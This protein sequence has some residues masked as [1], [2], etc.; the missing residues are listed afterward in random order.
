MSQKATEMQRKFMRTGSR[1]KDIFK[2][3]NTGWLDDNV[4]AVREWAANIFFYRKDG[5]TIMID[6]GYSYPGL[7]EK[8]GWLGI[9]PGEIKDI[10]IT[11]ED[12]DHIGAVEDDSD[13]LFED[14]RLYISE[15][16]N[17]YLTGERRR[18]TFFGL[19][20]LEQVHVGN[21]RTL[22]HDGDV[23]HIGSIKVE[24]FLVPGH[25]WGHTN[26]LIDDE[27]MFTGDS[28]WLGKDGGYS[29]LSTLA[30]SNRVA[31]AELSAFREKL[32][33]RNLHP[34]FITGHTGATDNT[35]FTFRHTGTPA[36]IFKKRVPDPSAPYDPYDESDDTEEKARG[37]RLELVTAE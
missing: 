24:A 11:H 20:R 23:F 7:K 15:E 16:E 19:Y 6:A 2:P 13:H 29:F 3:M 8:M 10:L 36:S 22:L 30:E 34:L 37:K 26:Y 33:K 18:K 17:R 35:E 21:R 14:A 5:E 12:T 31:V 25:T 9:T 1:G 28:I 4:A 32:E 27:Y